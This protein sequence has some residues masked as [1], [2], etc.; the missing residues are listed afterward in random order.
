MGVIEGMDQW[1]KQ[2]LDEVLI[3]L[4]EESRLEEYKIKEIEFKIYCPP[5]LRF[6]T[7]KLDEIYLHATRRIITGI[8]E[9]EPTQR[10]TELS[11]IILGSSN[12]YQATFPERGTLTIY[13]ASTGRRIQGSIPVYGHIEVDLSSF[14]AGVYFGVYKPQEGRHQVGKIIKTQ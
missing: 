2:T 13:E 3:S 10:P 4:I 12:P 9:Q 14:P 1:S 5:E 6:N 8:E 11:D 7:A